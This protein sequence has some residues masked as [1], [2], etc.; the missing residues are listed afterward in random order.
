VELDIEKLQRRLGI[1][2]QKNGARS[3]WERAYGPAEIIDG[4]V[5]G[6]KI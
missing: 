5:N 4:T 1:E 3:C 6:K 2:P